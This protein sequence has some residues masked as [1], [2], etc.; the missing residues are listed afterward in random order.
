L[1]GT[2]SIRMLMALIC[3]GGLRSRPILLLRPAVVAGP[4]HG[5]VGCL[6][7]SL[8]LDCC[9]SSCWPAMAARSKGGGAAALAVFVFSGGSSR[10]R[11]SGVVSGGFLHC[12]PVGFHG[13]GRRCRCRR[14]RP[15]SI[16]IRRWAQLPLLLCLELELLLP[17]RPAVV[18]RDWEANQLQLASLR[19]R[20]LSPR[21]CGR[22]GVSPR[23]QEG[24]CYLLT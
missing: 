18:A 15:L 20:R 4:G 6:L 24:R 5:G 13:G 11:C 8:P 2:G 3:G 12:N 19:F 17:L 16:T 1:E 21:A 23:Q 9:F 22:P 10:P 14:R 7:C